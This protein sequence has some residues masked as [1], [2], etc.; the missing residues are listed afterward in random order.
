MTLQAA[1][2]PLWASSEC[3]AFGVDPGTRYC[4]W[5]VVRRRGQ[6]LERLASGCIAPKGKMHRRLGLISAD[7]DRLVGAWPAHLV[8]VEDTF[9]GSNPQAALAVCSARGIAMAAAGKANRALQLYSPSAIKSAVALHGQAKK[10]QINRAVRSFLALDREL[11]ED[12]ADA[13]A[14]AICAAVSWRSK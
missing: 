8:A 14:I 1:Q 4:G 3:I 7:L 11:Q 2:T 12:E 5:G 13:L 6:R 9:I 10:D